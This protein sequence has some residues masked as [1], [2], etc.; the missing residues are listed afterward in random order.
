MSE[1]DENKT[2]WITLKKW[3]EQAGTFSLHCGGRIICGIDTRFFFLT[4]GLIGVS[5]ALFFLLVVPFLQESS[6]FVVIGI[7][8]ILYILMVSFMLVAAFTDPGFIPRGDKPCPKKHESWINAQ[9]EKFC[10][11]CRIWRPLRAIHCR[12]CNAC[13][14]KLDHHCPWIG[15]CVGER[16]YKYFFGFLSTLTLYNLV[17]FSGSVLQ[18]VEE[19]VTQAKSRGYDKR[20]W[21]VGLPTAIEKYPISVFLLL[22]TGSIFVSLSPLM[23]YHAHL[24]GINQTTNENI[25]LVYHDSISFEKKINP[26]NLGCV[27]NYYNLCCRASVESQILRRASKPPMWNK[28]SS[29]FHKV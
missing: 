12:Y 11:T 7:A 1:T 17:I 25:K 3:Q 6:R 4:N 23:L 27:R 5:T 8:G 21:I 24:I 19:A 13:V 28:R 14:K 26:H 22:Y 18:L 15:T 10:V 20:E 2:D 16:N 9:G 29:G